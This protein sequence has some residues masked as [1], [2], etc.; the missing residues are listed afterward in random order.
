VAPAL[1]VARPV[2]LIGSM[3]AGQNG[4][5][6]T[7]GASCRIPNGCWPGA[8]APLFWFHGD[9]GRDQF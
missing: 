6:T 3:L 8:A 7:W 2:K 1:R 4:Q 9:E 5:V